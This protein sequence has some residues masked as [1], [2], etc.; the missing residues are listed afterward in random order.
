MPAGW[1]GRACLVAVLAAL[2]A[3]C[4]GQQGPGGFDPADA[5]ELSCTLTYR[6]AVTEPI[7]EQE[8]VVVAP[9]ET[10]TVAFDPLEIDLV[11]DVSPQEGATLRIDAREPGSD[12]P[13]VRNLYQFTDDGPP[14]DFAGQTGFTGLTYLHP[15]GTDAEVQYFCSADAADA[16]D[17]AGAQDG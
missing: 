9:G 6:S 13:F 1:R 10:R 8:D 5:V 14:Q 17:A 3:G 2:L 12:E 15:P 16:A 11:Y 7:Q 4:S